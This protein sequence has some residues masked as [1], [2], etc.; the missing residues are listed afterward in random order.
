ME[1]KYY[2]IVTKSKKEKCTLN[3]DLICC[4]ENLDN[5]PDRECTCKDF[6]NYSKTRATYHLTENE[7]EQLKNDCR[8]KSINL[9]KTFNEGMGDVIVNF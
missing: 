6:K 4:T 1:K 5:I 8:V 7:V 9:D 3:N 2:T